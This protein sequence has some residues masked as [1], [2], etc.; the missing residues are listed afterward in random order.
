MTAHETS[1]AALQEAARNRIREKSEYRFGLAVLGVIAALLVTIWAVTSP[2]GY[3]W[4]VWPMFGTAVPMLF[5]LAG[6][7]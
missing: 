4:P 5:M 7:R 6:R 2:G 3:F 1:G